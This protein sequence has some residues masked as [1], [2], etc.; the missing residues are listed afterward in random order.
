[1]TTTDA[2]E[3]RDALFLRGDEARAAWDRLLSPELIEMTV[4]HLS[5]M[6]TS[7]LNDLALRAAQQTADY[8]TDYVEWRRRALGFKRAVD[9]HLTI[10]KA[11]L[12]TVNRARSAAE[13][14]ASRNV[15]RELAEAVLAHQQTTRDLGVDPEPHDRELWSALDRLVVPLNDGTDTLRHLI[16]EGAWF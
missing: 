14:T 7:V 13:V 4:A 12:K 6:C 15:L 16:T 10:A 5:T 8:S 9:R 11:T 3:I 1:M 2:D